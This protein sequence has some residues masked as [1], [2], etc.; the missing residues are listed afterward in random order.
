MT[1]KAIPIMKNNG[2]K[3]LI[4]WHGGKLFVTAEAWNCICLVGEDGVLFAC[5]KMLCL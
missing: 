1:V 3:V 5:R 2:Q 4:T